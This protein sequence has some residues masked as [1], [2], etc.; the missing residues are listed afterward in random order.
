MNYKYFDHA[1]TTK[2]DERVMKEMIPYMEIE[3]GNPSSLYTLGRRAKHAVEEAREKI[4]REIKCEKKEI[5]F[6]SCG[7]ESDNLAIKGVA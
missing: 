6:T 7:S 3:Y 1:A 4:A 2:V 5:Y